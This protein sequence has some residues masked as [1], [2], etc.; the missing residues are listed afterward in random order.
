M[1]LRRPP[2]TLLGGRRFLAA[3]G[4][5]YASLATL[6]VAVQLSSGTPL[7]NTVVV[8]AFIAGSGL[9]LLLGSYRLPRTE[10]DPRFYPTITGWCLTA[11]G[12]ML[13]ILALYHAQP[14]V[15]LT[16]PDRS[17]L[18]LTGFSSVAGFGIGTYG[19]R[20]KTH[21]YELRIQNQK[22]KRTQAQLEE[23]NE[24]LE[25]FAYA[26]SHDLQEPLRMISSYLQLIETRYGDDLDADGRE[27]I[28]Y[29]VDGSERMTA[30]IDGLLEFSRVETRGA[31][32]ETVALEDVV[33]AVQQDLSLRIEQSQADVTVESLPRVRGDRSQLRQVFQNLITNA[34]E[35][36][37]DDPPTITISA[38]RDGEEWCISVRDEGIG[39]EPSQQDRVF[40]VFHRLHSHEEH[41]GTGIGL[42]LCNRIIERHDGEIWLESEPGIATTVS[43]TLASADSL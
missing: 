27:F 43:F 13:G 17:I 22:L 7:A 38:E 18:I 19:A 30:M 10:I 32:L 3:I 34:I 15:G 5:L 41:T 8:F 23:S 24:Y 33:A 25:Q 20:A 1:H 28:A 39:V 14:S 40:E 35:Y 9:V 37:G 31:P 2:V 36:S 4:G 11:I 26:A 21:A 42:A 12:V 16:N 6:W 29:A